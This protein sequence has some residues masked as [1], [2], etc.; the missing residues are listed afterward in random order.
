LVLQ[1][2]DLEWPEGSAA[3]TVNLIGPTYEYGPG[4]GPDQGFSITGGVVYRG[5][6]FPNLYGYY[7][8]ADYVSGNVWALNVD[9]P[10]GVQRLLG[11]TGIAG[12]G[13]D[14]RKGDVLAAAHDSGKILRLEY[15]AGTNENLPETLSETGIFADLTS[16]TPNRGIYPYE[17][18]LPFW[19]DHAQKRRWFSIPD[20]SKKIVFSPDSNWQFPSGSVWVKHFELEM[21]RGQPSTAKR[22]ET[23]ILV[24][25]EPGLYGVV[26][27]WN[28]GGSNAV[29]V[30]EEGAQQSYQIQEN[31]ITRTQVWQFPSRSECLNCHTA[32][33][34]HIIG[35]NSPQ[36]NRTSDY[37]AGATNQIWAWAEA[38]FFENPPVTLRG[39]RA[40]TDLTDESVSREFR[41]RSYLA[42]NCV[43]CHQ[44]SGSAYGVW[45]GRINT[46]LSAAQLL[47]GS[48]YNNY[49]DSRNRVVVAGSLEHSTLLHRIR[50]LDKDRMPPIASTVLDQTAIDLLS[51]WITNDLPQYESY[52]AWTAL[53][54]GSLGLPSSARQADPD[55]DGLNNYTEYLVAANP[56]EAHGALDAK[57]ALQDGQFYLSFTQPANRAVL[58]ESATDLADPRWQIADAPNNSIFFPSA[59]LS[60][61]FSEPMNA[62]T[63]FLR[64]RILEP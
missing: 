7:V 21:T 29:L 49:G 39:L 28:D 9:R 33:G 1:G 19:S 47:N 2:R 17:V 48:L 20:P 50:I 6:R 11:Q 32:V 13:T 37:G 43:F 40:L 64:L 53:F 36:L 44:P 55:G 59:P 52:D 16:L 4:F 35:F 31:G 62:Q 26:Y 51:S 5:R 54:F 38:G 23:R 60:R 41:V 14:P 8:F 15:T 30:P 3:G 22:I 56:L 24:K 12:F 25:T 57:T 61:V 42:A 45:D 34:G 10:N 58:I 63:R 27:R 46:P 18:N